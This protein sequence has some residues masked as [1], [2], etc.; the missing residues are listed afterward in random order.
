MAKKAVLEV[1]GEP[2]KL[3]KKLKKS[4]PEERKTK[5]EVAMEAPAKPKKKRKKKNTAELLATDPDRAMKRLQETAASHGIVV[6][7][8][9]LRVENPELVFLRTYERIFKRLLKFRKKMERQMNAGDTIQSRDVY[10]YNV[11]CNQTREVMADMRSLIDMTQMAETLC[12]EALDPLAKA[13]AQAVTTMLMTVQSTLRSKAPGVM[14]DVMAEIKN[15]GGQIG[16]D[17]KAQ[18]DSSRS[19]LHQL[20]AQSK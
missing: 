10:A 12:V 3:K 6:T 2:I 5:A 1:S 13:S 19:K 9:E 16:I 18:L 15:A 11:L 17:L 7:Q 4:K 20:L 8:E 14:E